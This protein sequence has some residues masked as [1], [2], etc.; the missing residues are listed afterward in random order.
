[1][2]KKVSLFEPIRFRWAPVEGTEELDYVVSVVDVETGP[3]PECC[4]V[5]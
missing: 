2:A 5:G 4:I 1:M 3:A